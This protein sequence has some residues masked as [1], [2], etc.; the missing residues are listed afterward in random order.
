MK[1]RVI[2]FYSWKGGVG[3]S[4]ALANVGVQLA[5][6]GLR[7]LL[8]DWDLEAPGLE[9]YFFPTSQGGPSPVDV[10]ESK[11][12][13][14]LLGLLC[15]V[16]MASSDLELL[17]QWKSRCS[18]INILSNSNSQSMTESSN[19]QGILSLLGS[20]IRSGQYSELLQTFSW[21]SFFSEKNGVDLIERLRC[22]WLEDYDI[23]LVDS[24]TGLTD[25]GSVC[26]VQLP[27][28]LV[29]VFTACSQSI[30]EG[31][32]F[33]DG[34][35]HARKLF[36]NSLG[37]L[38][39]IPLL[40]RWDGEDEVD[41]A[42]EWQSRIEPI[43]CPYVESWLPK[44]F[45]VRRMLE[46]L[47]VPH[48]AR[49]SFGE[50]LPVL[51][52]SITDPKLPGKAFNLIAKLI[53]NDLSHAG[54][55]LDPSY[56]QPFDP[57]ILSDSELIGI[58]LDA[59]SRND[60]IISVAISHGRT[61]VKMIDFLRRVSDA[62]YQNRNFQL[63]DEIAS[64]AV[65]AAR[66]LSLIDQ[67]N[68]V[69]LALYRALCCHADIGRNLSGIAISRELNHEAALVINRLLELEPEN[70][71]LKLKLLELCNRLGNAS[72]ELFLVSKRETKD[73]E[74]LLNEAYASFQD[75]IC[76]GEELLEVG[77]NDNQ[78]RIL[79]CSSL[80]KYGELLFESKRFDDALLSFKRSQKIREILLKEEPGSEAF[81]T[82]LA[83]TLEKI[84][85][86]FCKLGNDGKARALYEQAMKC[87]APEVRS[88]S[89]PDSRRRYSSILFKLGELYRSSGEIL[90]AL[91]VLG[92]SISVF[93]L[94]SQ[95]GQE[96]SQVEKDLVQKY[97]DVL[98]EYGSLQ[99]SKGAARA[100]TVPLEY[101]A[102]VPGRCQRQYIR[103]PAN[104]PP[105]W[106]TDIQQW[107]DEWV[108]RVDNV[109]PF[110]GG[111]LRI[112]EVQIDWRLISNSGVDEGIIRPVIGA[113]GWPMI[114]GSGIKGLFRRACAPHRLESW[115]GSPCASGDL[116]PGILRFH[117]AW[118]ADASWA[119]GLL[120]VAHPQQN[121]QVGFTHGRESHSAF[122]AVSLHR[123]KL[124]IGLSCANPDIS[125]AEWEEI[126]DTLQ[127]GLMAGIGGRTCVGY[128]SSGQIQGDVLFQ[129]A[130]DGQGPAAK[131]LDES[132]EFRPTM[133]RA[134]IRGMALRLFGGLTDP[135]TALRV[136][137]ELF[138][139]LSREEGQHVGLLATSYIDAETSL[140]SHGRGSWA[141]P[142]Y[143][144]SGLL[145]WRLTRSPGMDAATPLLAELLAAL[146]GLTMSLGGFGRGWRR[147]DH[148][149]FRPGYDKTPIGCHWQWRD[150]ASL[151]PSIHIQSP[152]GLARLL[153]QSRRLAC[154]WLR[155]TGQPI[156]G[157]APWR[158]VIHPQQMR[159]WTRRATDPSDAEAVAWF[160]NSPE[161]RQASGI[162]T[163]PCNLKRTILAGQMN[164][165]GLIWNRLLPLLETG[166]PAQTAT[167]AKP[168]NP[169]ARPS[170]AAVARPLARPAA[171]MAR[172]AAARQ[173]ARAAQGS[174]SIAVHQ[175]AYLESLVLHSLPPAARP[176]DRRHHTAF[177]AEMNRG[178]GANFTPL[179]WTD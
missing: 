32:R 142:I 43:I 51:T 37:R 34:V 25:S 177:V 149:I 15:E 1:P 174:V 138:G 122:G 120:D 29:L 98:R 11:N 94:A 97:E 20:G 133:F 78:A 106:R 131:L 8:I 62:L 100:L 74:K 158:E 6:G 42:T 153:R 113:G 61:S 72:W 107:I 121:W 112:V 152:E 155:G 159:I 172:P 54:S 13:S 176:E 170:P 145:Q 169:L 175:G 171:A 88:F 53:S 73:G 44:D 70:R 126:V 89:T 23:V 45:A 16:N 103:K 109:S 63:A 56:K 141:Q 135:G 59:N 39:I 124:R 156:G 31:L 65:Q 140:G 161:D 179:E 82:D 125:T 95:G 164:Q 105:G 151:P 115:C 52:H 144:T 50:Q 60:A 69:L 111:G 55:I 154:E 96:G 102:Q 24:R 132:A 46:E 17:N 92:E 128:G 143:A 160:H 114:P 41:L 178:A 117:G 38:T 104:A 134:A 10:V 87:F 148:R 58:A 163:D 108:E 67:S 162:Q 101:R 90:S 167:P 75:A 86:L 136:V 99:Q 139:S 130:L 21:R 110:N 137:G 68:I 9:R 123:P 48:V 157:P 168:A 36:P 71:S 77:L 57:A 19:I 14:G 35:Q 91:K 147:P 28:I 81:I 30:E 76:I 49:F 119:A 27:E 4:F 150:V 93:K 84:G 165:V 5:L 33:I 47:R 22:Q 7:V 26:T 3:R 80:D 64:K 146:H 166:S 18:Q 116:H 173:T 127:R 2:T 118:P 66:E 85:D 83:A 40:S 12:L 79:L 129:C